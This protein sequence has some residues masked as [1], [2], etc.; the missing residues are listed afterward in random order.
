MFR[1]FISPYIKSSKINWASLILRAGLGLLMIPHGYGKYSRF[2]EMSGQFMDFMG[3]GSSISLGLAVFAELICSAML[4]LGLATRAV[5]I[6]LIITMLTA[7]FIA[8]AGGPLGEKE[9]SLMY[10]IGY[11]SIFIMGAGKYS[12][13]AM[14][15]K[16]K[17]Y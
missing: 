12:L 3:L 6:P 9:H 8:H 1:T 16:P 2:E 14:V 5:L 15:F 4:V 17:A 10:L 7:A 11:L 13:D